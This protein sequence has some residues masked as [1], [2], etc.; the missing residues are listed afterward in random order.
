[1]PYDRAIGTFK[2]KQKVSG[3]FCSSEGTHV[4]AVIRSVINTI[5]KNGQNLT[6]RLATLG[7]AERL[8]KNQH[9]TF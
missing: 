3:L 8:Q 4:F 9:P 1:M 2:V 5:I 6:D 7:T